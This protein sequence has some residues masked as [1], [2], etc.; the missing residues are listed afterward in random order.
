[1]DPFKLLS[2]GARVAKNEG[3]NLNNFCFLLDFTSFSVFFLIMKT[4]YKTVL[5]NRGC[6][7]K[8][9]KKKEITPHACTQ[10]CVLKSRLIV[11][12]SHTYA[13]AAFRVSV[14]PEWP[15]EK[16]A[17]KTSLHHY[18]TEEKSSLYSWKISHG[19]GPW[20]SRVFP[21]GFTHDDPLPSYWHA[22]QIPTPPPPPPPNSPYL[23]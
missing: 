1:M 11:P 17:E 23:D 6:E 15:S 20:N 21:K 4:L 10:S 5:P 14:R 9:R 22:H 3:M 8:W 2:W 18:K 12:H 19:S 7:Q 13:H 16:G